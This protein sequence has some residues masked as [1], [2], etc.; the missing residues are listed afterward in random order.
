MMDAKILPQGCFEQ[1][2]YLDVPSQRLLYQKP[3]LNLLYTS[4]ELIEGGS[5]THQ[6]EN[7]S[8]LIGS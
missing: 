3:L 7:S 1:S 2:G 5:T 6:L 8:G 4:A